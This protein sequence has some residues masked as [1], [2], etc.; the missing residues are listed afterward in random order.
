MACRHGND[1]EKALG[2]ANSSLR[3]LKQLE[4]QGTRGTPRDM[5]ARVWHW[6]QVVDRNCLLPILVVSMISLPVGF[7]SLPP[8]LIECKKQPLDLQVLSDVRFR[9]S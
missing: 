6:Q 5:K 1:L 9:L 8:G 4:R 2:R 7:S 3:Q